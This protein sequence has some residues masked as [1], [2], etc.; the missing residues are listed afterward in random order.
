MNT[1]TTK[2][3]LRFKGNTIE[4]WESIVVSPLFISEYTTRIITRIVKLICDHEIKSK[5]YVCF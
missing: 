5:N 3:K 2:K 1:N 4:Y